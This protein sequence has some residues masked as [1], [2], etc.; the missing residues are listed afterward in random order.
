M[1]TSLIFR[2]RDFT[3]EPGETVVLHNDIAEKNGYVYW[4][5]WAKSHETVP[6]LFLRR[7]RESMETI[8]LFDS[9]QH[10]LFRTQLVGFTSNVDPIEAPERDKCPPYYSEKRCKI[11]LKLGPITEV[12]DPVD[13]L[14][15]YSY[16]G[17]NNN[18][19]NASN[20]ETLF[21]DFFNKQV[22]N[23]EELFHQERTIWFLQ[24]YVPNEHKSHSVIL[25]NVGQLHPEVYSKSYKPIYGNQIL[26]LSDV[27]FDTTS[28]HHYYQ[29]E[30]IDKPLGE[31]LESFANSND[32]KFNG[33]IPALICSGDMTFQALAEEFIETE[34][35]YGE[36]ASKCQLDHFNIAFC[37]GNHD[38]TFAG[39][40]DPDI[41]K[42]F[43]EYHRIKMQPNNAERARLNEDDWNKLKA[44]DTKNISKTNYE[45][46]F[47]KITRSKPNEYLSMGRKFLANEQRPVDICMLNSNTVQQYRDIYQG[48]GFV[49]EEQRADA[50]TKMGWD[51]PKSF[52]TVRIV[53]LHHNLLPVEYGNI[54]VYGHSSNLIYDAQATIQWCMENDVD[55]VLH[56]HTH[57]TSYMKLSQ[58]I[59]G[60]MKNLW[61]VGLGSTGASHNHLVPGHTNQFGVLDFSKQ[62]VQ[63]TF[64][65]HLNGKHTV[66]NTIELES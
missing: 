51:K 5:W 44:L 61:I 39:D 13:E 32:S 16:L 14:N 54:P 20:D 34:K 30:R 50:K 42:A 35:L 57:Q 15:T 7:Q 40:I 17:S 24:N 66:L 43:D 29:D 12:E 59:Q 28:N 53:S 65:E 36:L 47:N 56:G 52:G 26:W 37:P 62:F 9:G 6:D 2:F 49:G 11:W 21:S 18:L 64:V 27:H 60:T 1:I 31:I 38:V 63:I 3:I 41:K 33:K 46:H 48:H 4:G 45:T 23:L 55:V 19:F 58:D 8:Y 25:T 22:S 10:K